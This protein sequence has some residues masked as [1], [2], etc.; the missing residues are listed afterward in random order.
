[1]EIPEIAK[2][3]EM[4]EPVSD[5]TDRGCRDAAQCGHCRH[6]QGF[7]FERMETSLDV[8]SAL[9]LLEGKEPGRGF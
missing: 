3:N 9:G 4:H 2:R 8:D 7:T 1:M 6:A 5:G